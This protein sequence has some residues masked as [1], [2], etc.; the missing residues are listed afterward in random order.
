VGKAEK[1][2]IKRSSDVKTMGTICFQKQ[3]KW[4][5]VILKKFCEALK[6]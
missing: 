2:D 5:A 4:I 6:A 1:M 3:G